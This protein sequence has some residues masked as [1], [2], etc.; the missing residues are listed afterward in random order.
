RRM[1]PR[2]PAVST[3]TA[4]PDA[5]SAM[6]DRLSRQVIVAGAGIAGLTA[7]LAFAQR[8]FSVRVFEQA[9]RFEPLGAG[10]QLSPNATRLLDRLGVLERLLAEAVRPAAV[11]LRDAAS[12]RVLARIPLGEAGERRWHAPYLAAH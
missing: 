10:L 4:R 1:K 12:L 8:G 6:A 7:A 11:L 5:R 2:R 3:S 9:P